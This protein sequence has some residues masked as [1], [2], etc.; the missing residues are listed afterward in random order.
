MGMRNGVDLRGFM[1]NR[2]MWGAMVGG[3]QQQTAFQTFEAGRELDAAADNS[4]TGFFDDIH[5]RHGPSWANQT[6][7]S[8]ALSVI[9]PT[10]ARTRGVD[11]AGC[12]TLPHDASTLNAARAVLS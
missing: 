5:G 3:R 6:V 4:T 11:L 8:H 1:N 9:P 12:P 10:A 7:N 2:G